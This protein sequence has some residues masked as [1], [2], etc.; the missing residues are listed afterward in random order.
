MA[1][2]LT[3]LEKIDEI[4]A[5]LNKF[6]GDKEVKMYISKTDLEVLKRELNEEYGHEIVINNGNILRGNL[7]MLRLFGITFHFT[8]L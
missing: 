8:E 7:L 5:G 4:I 2:E 6:E 1:K 3:P